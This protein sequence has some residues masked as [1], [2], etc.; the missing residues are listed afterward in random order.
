MAPPKFLRVALAAVLLVPACG[1]FESQATRREKAY[2]RYLGNSWKAQQQ[3]QKEAAK[4]KTKVPAGGAT[5]DRNIRTGPEAATTPGPTPPPGE[6][7]PSPPQEP[8]Q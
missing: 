6:A 3:R 8:A 5:D 7:P 1:L 2:E 4:H